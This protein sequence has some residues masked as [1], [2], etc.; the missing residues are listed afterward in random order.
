LCSCGAWPVVVV[1]DVDERQRD[2][3][4]LRFVP[5]AVELSELLLMFD[6]AWGLVVVFAVCVTV[7]RPRSY[8]RRVLDAARSAVESARIIGTGSNK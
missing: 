1:D 6:G 7:C 4:K 3:V 2:Q 8:L 5:V